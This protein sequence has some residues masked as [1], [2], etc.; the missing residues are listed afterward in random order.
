MI[1][2]KQLHLDSERALRLAG[3]W[4][5]R[6]FSRIRTGWSST[7]SSAARSRVCGSIILTG[8]SIRDWFP[9]MPSVCAAWPS[10]WHSTLA[11][12]RFPDT[13][14]HG[15]FLLRIALVLLALVALLQAIVDAFRPSGSDAP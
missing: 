11:L 3:G 15:Y 10:V 14:N 13:F 4:R 1:D 5:Y 12:E 6:S 2:A 9:R 7:W 8:C